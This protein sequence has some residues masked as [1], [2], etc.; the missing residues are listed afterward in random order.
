MYFG[1]A[2]PTR[3]KAIPHIPDCS[4]GQEDIPDCSAGQEEFPPIDSQLA[5]TG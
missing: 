5:D 2:M 4:A 3:V 1:A